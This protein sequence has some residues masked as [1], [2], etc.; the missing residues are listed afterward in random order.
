MVETRSNKAV[1]HETVLRYMCD[2]FRVRKPE[3]DVRL[4]LRLI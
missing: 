2:E 1:Q 4:P 3:I